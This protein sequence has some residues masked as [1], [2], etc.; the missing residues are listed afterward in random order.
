MIG[1]EAAPYRAMLELSHPVAE[2][3]VKNWE[4][5]SLVWGHAFNKVFLL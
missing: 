4:D 5:M 3:I 1:D 2:G